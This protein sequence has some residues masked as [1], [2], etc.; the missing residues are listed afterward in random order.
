M[1]KQ[2]K[3]NTT[4]SVSVLLKS[5]KSLHVSFTP[6]SNGTSV[7]STSDEDVQRALEAHYRYGTLFREVKVVPA[8]VPQAVKPAT[9]EK[10]PEDDLKHVTVSDWGMAKEWLADNMGI[11]RT[12]LRGKVAI[13]AAAAQNNV[14]FDGLE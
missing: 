6:L 4:I 11:S 5:G 1:L 12:Q 7:F 9:V 3:A 14:V 13:L 2:Y 8:A 10:K